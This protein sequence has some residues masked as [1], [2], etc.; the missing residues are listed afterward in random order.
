[1]S[2]RAATDGSSDPA[3]FNTFPADSI[4]ER[5]GCSGNAAVGFGRPGGL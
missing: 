5:N 1:M 3:S 4:F 2:R